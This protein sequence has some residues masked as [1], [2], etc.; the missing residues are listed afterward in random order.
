MNDKTDPDLQALAGEIKHLREDFARVGTVL[1][2]LLRHRTSAAANEATRRATEAWD[3]VNRRAESA[4]HTIEQ[5][6][7]TTVGGAFG[8]GLVLGMLFSGRRS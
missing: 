3:E 7:L 8:L 5:N 6:P 2:D 4:A 1:E